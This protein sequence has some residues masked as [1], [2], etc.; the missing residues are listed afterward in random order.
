MSDQSPYRPPQSSVNEGEVA[1]YVDTRLVGKLGRV[2]FWLIITTF[3]LSVLQ[4]A[5]ILALGG[6]EQMSDPQFVWSGPGI[7]VSIFGC[8][9]SLVVLTLVV[10]WLVWQHRAHSN[11]VALGLMKGGIS[12]ALGV[13]AWFIPIANLVLPMLVTREIWSRSERLEPPAKTS[14]PAFFLW[15]LGWLA[16]WGFMSWTV[17]QTIKSFPAPYAPST[18]ASL[19]GLVLGLVNAAAAAILVRS[20]SQAQE[21]LTARSN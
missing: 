3:G 11:L 21:R 5:A 18:G 19:G 12:P 8:G 14:H 16:A 6:A 13:V 9:S 10:I 20:I 15:W 1:G 4:Q 17:V 7:L 2:M